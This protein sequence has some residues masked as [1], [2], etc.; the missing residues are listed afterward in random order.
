MDASPRSGRSVVGLPKGLPCGLAILDAKGRIY[1]IDASY[2]GSEKRELDHESVYRVDPDGTVTRII[3]DVQKP[4]GIVVSADQKTLSSL[5]ARIPISTARLFN[6]GSVPGNPRQTGHVFVLG[7]S[8][9]CVEQL[10]N[11]FVL[12]K[13][14]T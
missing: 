12:V 6:T 13:S 5:A 11:I 2:I 1:F 7:G 14:W 4:N 10:Q 3:S 9:N 8:P